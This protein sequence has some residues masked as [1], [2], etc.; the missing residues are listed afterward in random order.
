MLVSIAWCVRRR[1]VQIESIDQFDATRRTVC[2]QCVSHSRHAS[3]CDTIGQ[4]TAIGLSARCSTHRTAVHAT[5][6]YYT[7]V[8]RIVSVTAGSSYVDHCKTER[9]REYACAVAGGSLGLSV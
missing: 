6:Q 1:Y 3:G 5:V 4:D 9:G 7:A 2:F 8:V